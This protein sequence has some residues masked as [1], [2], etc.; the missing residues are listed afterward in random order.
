MN[1]AAERTSTTV[2]TSFSEAV[3]NPDLLQ[4][5][6][7]VLLP[8]KAVRISL[9]KWREK[10]LHL[11]AHEDAP[12]KTH[13]EAQQITPSPP[14]VTTE[15]LLC[16]PLRT[17]RPACQSSFLCVP[18]D[19][20]AS[21]GSPPV[22]ATG[23]RSTKQN[24]ALQ[25]PNDASVPAAAVRD[26]ESFLLEQCSPTPRDMEVKLHA[27]DLSSGYL[28]EY[29][30]SLVGIQTP[31]V[32]H[33]G[34]VCYGIEVYF[35]GGIGV[36]AAGRTRF[37]NMYRTHSLGVTRKTVTEFLRWVAVRA[38][39]RNQIHDYHPIRYNCHHF[40]LE[41]TQFLLG[42][43]ASIPKYLFSTVDDLLNTEV[44]AA[45][46]EAMTITTLG[47][48]SAV[49]RQ[50]RSRTSERQRSL[51]MQLSSSTACGVMKLP[52]TA[53]V[54]F[55]VNDRDLARQLLVGLRPYINRLINEKAIKPA[56]LALLEEMASALMEGAD[57][58]APKL[59]LNYVE[60]VTESLLHNPIT[61]WGP[62]FNGLRIA[63]L[64]KLCL[65]P[66]VFHTK[67]MSILVLAA[68]DFPRLLP[69]GRVA[70][71]RLVCNFACSAHG[72]LV[73]SE[74]RYRD[75]WVSIVGLGLIDSSSTVVYTAA[76]LSLNLALSSVITSTPSLKREM[77]NQADDHYALRLATLLLCSLR[78]RSQEQ[79]PEPSFNM[80]LMALYR[81]ASSNSVALK[82]IMLHTFKPHYRELLDRCG[83]ND[84]RA[85]VCLLRTLEDLYA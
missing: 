62:I 38:V 82:Y 66:C 78:N 67:L 37:G 46:A 45:V 44:G 73:L 12:V 47:M 70:L 56:A 15:L 51:N 84:S 1:N 76:C 39:H 85:L 22:K 75:A 26:G 9:C 20:Q 24:T 42:E 14:L 41:A 57:C 83:S 3:K 49:A 43:S 28:K 30:E 23:N 50:L 17:P 80:I 27:Y 77:M 53:A 13:E 5:S 31:G 4:E 71:L 36:S 79:L 63:V 65:I 8:S 19:A 18:L 48:Q 16:S 55:R 29:G 72:A 10:R 54:L 7:S 11:S 21:A 74:K 2:N 69:D 34:L 33:S 68:R 60:M 35:E 40:S 81:L 6:E 61:T 59:V 58:I 32:Y 52:P 64:H 25:P